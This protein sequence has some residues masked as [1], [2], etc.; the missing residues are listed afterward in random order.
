MQDVIVS[1]CD[2]GENSNITYSITKGNQDQ[3]FHVVNGIIQVNEELDFEQNQQFTL[4]V[5]ARDNGEPSLSSSAEVC[6]RARACV[7]VRVCVCVCVCACVRVCMCMC[8]CACARVCV[9][10]NTN[11]RTVCQYEY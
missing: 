3:K 5:L 11:L 2:T 4:T 6:V 8:V 1:D 9:C 7:C 10:A